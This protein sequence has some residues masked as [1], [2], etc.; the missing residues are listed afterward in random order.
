MQD[1][2]AEAKAYLQGAIK[3]A[4]DLDIG[5]GAGPLQHFTGRR[6]R[7]NKYFQAFAACKVA[8]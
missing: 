3:R 1:A 7:L 8:A 6:Q 5:A 2:I 4:S